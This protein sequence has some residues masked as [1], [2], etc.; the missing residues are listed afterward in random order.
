MCGGKSHWDHGG[1]LLLLLCMMAVLRLPGPRAQG[2]ESRRANT[3]GVSQPV[4]CKSVGVESQELRL[5]VSENEKTLRL[6]LLV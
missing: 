1:Y 4:G 2:Q 3:S 5:M 6:A